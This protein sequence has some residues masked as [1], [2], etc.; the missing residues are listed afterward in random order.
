MPLQKWFASVSLRRV[1][2]ASN[3]RESKPRD[4]LFFVRCQGLMLRFKGP[5]IK[6]KDCLYLFFFLNFPS[7]LAAAVVYIVPCIF[8]SND[9]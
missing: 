1:K 8:I 5:L 3:S 6:C 4:F 9:G 2:K 7:N